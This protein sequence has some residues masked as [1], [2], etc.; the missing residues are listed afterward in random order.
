MNYCSIIEQYHIYKTILACISCCESFFMKDDQDDFNILRTLDKVENPTQRLLAGK[1][2]FSLGKLNYC[3]VAL[4]KK[5]LI[6]ISNFEKNPKKLKYIY[7]LTPRGIA[8]RAKLTVN[9]M[10]LKIRE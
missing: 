3:L 5:G 4:K 10:K 8:H 2:G 7:I 6:K 1:L 9:F